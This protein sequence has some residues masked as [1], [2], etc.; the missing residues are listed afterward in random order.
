[1]RASFISLFIILGLSFYSCGIRQYDSTSLPVSH[2]IWDSLLQK[3]V[4]ADGWVNYEGFARDS[5]SLNAYTDLLSNHHPNDKY[6]SE[7]ERLAYWINAYNAYTVAL[8]VDHFPVLSIKDIRNGVPFVNSVWD[9]KFIQIEG[10]VYDLNNIEHS[11]LRKEFEEPR[12]HFAIN[13]ASVS[14]PELLNQAYWPDQIEKQ[15]EEAAIRFINDENR[16]DLES[17]NPRISK[18]FRWFGGDFKIDGRGVVDYIN[19]YAEPRLVDKNVGYLD[20]NWQINDISN[21]MIFEE[22]TVS[23]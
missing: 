14:C 17:E 11:I 1:M 2:A 5:V 19:R 9:I 20:Y 23:N 6:W 22:S 13:C 10:A 8:I 12:I 21:R 16:N 7:E 18:I 3:H 4:D 15:L